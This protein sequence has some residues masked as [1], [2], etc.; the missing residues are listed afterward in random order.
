MH[1]CENVV[2]DCCIVS[3][4]CTAPNLNIEAIARKLWLRKLLKL[5]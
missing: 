1:Y 5:V 4:S 2:V 3:P